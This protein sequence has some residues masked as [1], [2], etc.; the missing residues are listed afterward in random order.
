MRKTTP[1]LLLILLG[2]LGWGMASILSIRFGGGDIY[3]AGSSLRAD[4]RG[5]RVLHDSLAQ[6]RPV[7]RNFGEVHGELNGATV[8]IFQTTVAQVEEGSWRPMTE[9]GAR[10]VL[11]FAPMAIQRPKRELK[12]LDLALTYS[13]PT[14]EMRDL[15]AWETGR[16]T[17]MSLEPGSPWIVLSTGRVVERAYGKGSLVVVANGDMFS[18]QSLAQQ[19]SPAL[20]A[21]IIGPANRVIFDESHFGIRDDPGVMVLVRRYGLLGLLV[22]LIGLALL[23]V[24]QAAFP[25]VPLPP[26]SVQ[27]L[28]LQSERTAQSGLAQLLRRGI[29]PAGLMQVCLQEWERIVR[30][31]PRQRQAVRRAVAESADPVTAFA[32]ATL[33]LERK[34]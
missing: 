23:F 28:E 21:Q 10:V 2:A 26:E 1:F 9:R 14:E 25:L 4:R 31:T 8:F 30:F 17:T 32:R 29:P 11:A 33:A 16:E 22:S 20:L 27:A 12:G 24:W 13:V 3:P 19:R 34:R 15:P 7:A 5:T 18:N 6:L